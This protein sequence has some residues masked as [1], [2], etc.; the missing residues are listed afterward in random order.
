MALTP[1]QIHADYLA[2]VKALASD[3]GFP[4]KGIAEAHTV[5]FLAAELLTL[6]RRFP[7]VARELETSIPGIVRM[8]APKAE[9]A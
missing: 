6:A 5:G 1:D 7:E 3:Y 2:A 4:G 8:G 9:A